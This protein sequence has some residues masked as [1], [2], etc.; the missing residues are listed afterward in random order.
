MENFGIVPD[1]IT[2]AKGVTSGYAPLG[3]MIISEK[4]HEELYEKTDGILWHSYT[5]SGHT[6]AAAVAIK[7]IDINK[8]E[9]LIDN[10][11]KMGAHKLKGF[12]WI[13][14]QNDNVIDV[15]GIC[16][17]GGISLER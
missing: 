1:I 16:L 3:G 4:M 11:N 13:K 10:V 17:L 6:T 2:M 7:N 12:E 15:R 14:E 5:Y 8:E 9:N